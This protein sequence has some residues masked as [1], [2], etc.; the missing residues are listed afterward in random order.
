ML[1]KDGNKI[2]LTTAIKTNLL[3]RLESWGNSKKENDYYSGDF[4]ENES[5]VHFPYPMLP[6]RLRHE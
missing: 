3:V 4:I 5:H 2:H 1:P 6:N